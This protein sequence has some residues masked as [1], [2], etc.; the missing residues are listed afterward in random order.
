MPGEV[1]RGFSELMDAYSGANFGNASIAFI[2]ERADA[3]V[4]AMFPR[5]ARYY[6]FNFDWLG[7][8]YALDPSDRTDGEPGVARIDLLER[9]VQLMDYAF[10]NFHN[11]MLL[12]DSDGVLD[13]ELFGEWAAQHPDALPLKP[14]QI[15]GYRIPLNLGGEHTLDNLEV[16][17]FEVELDFSAQI[18][19]HIEDL[20]EGTIITEI[21]SNRA[22]GKNELTS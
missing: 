18:D 2:P 8:Q 14:N 10:A 13:S 16:V 4:H 15:V 22:N 6:C 7:R 1:L 17:D 12:T 19:E 5:R 21:K 11:V 9:R 20:P 3:I